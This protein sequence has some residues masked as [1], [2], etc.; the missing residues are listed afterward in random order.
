MTFLAQ[1]GAPSVPTEVFAIV[2]I[3]GGALAFVLFLPELR[4]SADDQRSLEGMPEEW[5]LF[6]R[7]RLPIAWMC[8]FGM[9]AA[10]VVAA[11]IFV[12]AMHEPKEGE[13]WLYVELVAV[14]AGVAVALTVAVWKL[15]LRRRIAAIRRR[16]SHLEEVI[17]DD[18]EAVP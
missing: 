16:E 2:V 17:P 3:L 15:R 5:A 8:L 11:A 14:G 10:Q 7:L 6:V 4:S 9:L 1:G 18:D 12:D 13:P